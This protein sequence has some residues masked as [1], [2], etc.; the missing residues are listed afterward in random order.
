MNRNAPPAPLS[1]I[2]SQ[3]LSQTLSPTLSRRF[4]PVFRFHN[5]FR[6]SDFGFRAFPLAFSLVACT[7]LTG[8]FGFLK[9]ARTTA[10]HFVLTPLPPSDPGQA[11]PGSLSI[12][13]GQVKIPPYLF[14]T[15]LGIRHGTNE[16]VYL[17][18]MLWAERL[19][20]GLQRIIAANL[21]TLLPTDKIRFSSWR[22]DDVSAEVH[23][24]IEQFDVDTAGQGVLVAW[25]R[26]LSPGA[27]KTL[28]SGEARLL[29][30]GP[31]P[32]PDPS[33]AVSTLSELVA[34]FSRQL[35][36]AIKDTQ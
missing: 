14:D 7:C 1:L 33:G 12:G 20:N 5:F 15:S 6:I 16:I 21:S 27:E 19:D 17:Q 22:P 10:R 8:C 29:R 30:P 2:S 28:K 24:A 3:T 11:K 34:E 25:R 31:P 18:S 23:I 36:H 13:V 26:V 4:V 35:A 9:P 32:E